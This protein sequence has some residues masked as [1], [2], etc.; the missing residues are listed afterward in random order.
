MSVAAE[1]EVYAQRFRFFY[2]LWR[3]NQQQNRLGRIHVGGSPREI[4]NLVVVRIIQPREPDS[5]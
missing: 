4:G 5:V 2:Q 1:V 3:M